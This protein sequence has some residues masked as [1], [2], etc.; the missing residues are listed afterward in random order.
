MDKY[1][2]SDSK[3]YDDAAREWDRKVGEC[4]QANEM[5]R[6][7]PPKKI[8]YNEKL[9]LTAYKYGWYEDDETFFIEGDPIE[10]TYWLKCTAGV[11]AS[12]NLL[13]RAQCRS[14]FGM[15]ALYVEYYF[16]GGELVEKHRE[17]RQRLIEAIT[18]FAAGSD[19]KLLQEPLLPKP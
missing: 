17:V 12:G 1:P 11:D 10:P 18:K 2:R 7:A 9:G 16:L 5:C 4:I 3:T 19:P 14:A 15:G 6:A 13:A 8:A